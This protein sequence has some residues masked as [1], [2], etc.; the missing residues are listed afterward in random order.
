MFKEDDPLVYET[1]NSWFT[2]YEKKGIEK[3]DVTLEFEINNDNKQM[4]YY[5]RITQ[6]NPIT[7]PAA[8]EGSGVLQVRPV[9]AWSTPVWVENNE[10]K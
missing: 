3:M 2:S 1:L 6:K 9:V 7:L 4:V 8:L 10:N 5:L